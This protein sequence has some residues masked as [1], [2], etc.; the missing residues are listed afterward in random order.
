MERAMIFIDGSNLYRNLKSAELP[1]K[2]NFQK[3][4]EKLATG[5]TLI[6]TFYYNSP[7]PQEAMPEEYK[8]QRSFF[9]KIS[10][11]PRF[12]LI[13]GR[14]EKRKVT[15]DGKEGITYAEKGVDVNLAVDLIR[16]AILN[17]YDVAILVSEDGDFVPAVKVVQ[18]EGKR[19]IVALANKGYHLRNTC[20]DKIIL[21]AEYLRDCSL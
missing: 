1:T 18:E 20:D 19:V 7:V 16:F 3:F 12:E 14:L 2:L 9:S 13:K 8:K 17:K 6:K 10:S 4:V 21:D 5:C 15:V 11:I